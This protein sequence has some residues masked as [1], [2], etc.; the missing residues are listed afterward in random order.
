MAT[1]SLTD[2]LLA[3]ANALATAQDR[4]LGSVSKEFLGESKKLPNLMAGA[5]INTRRLEATMQR[6]SDEW[7]SNVPWPKGVHR[8]RRTPASV[9]D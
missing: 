2:D 8:P 7:P 3:V 5:D 1:M 9:E 4:T 6:F